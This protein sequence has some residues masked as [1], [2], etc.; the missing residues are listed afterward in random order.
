MADVKT[1][2]YRLCN[3]SMVSKHEANWSVV[4]S[5][6]STTPFALFTCKKE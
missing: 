3:I 4:L 5:N 6:L 1:A 2:N